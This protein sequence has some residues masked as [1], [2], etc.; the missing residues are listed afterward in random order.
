MFSGL[1]FD[2][3]YDKCHRFILKEIQDAVEEGD[4]IEC[5]KHCGAVPIAELVNAFLKSD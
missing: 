3:G 4:T 5:P 2:M 1:D